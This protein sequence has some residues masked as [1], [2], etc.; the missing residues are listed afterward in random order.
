MK[1]EPR[2]ER[3]TRRDGEGK[4]EEPG[5]WPRGVD[6]VL[7]E[8]GHWEFPAQET[9]DLSSGKIHLA[10]ASGETG[11]RE[12]SLQFERPGN[13]FW[14]ERRVAPTNEGQWAGKVRAGL[15]TVCL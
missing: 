5:T 2:G 6:S 9:S 1:L 7:G 8:I 4:P 11:S 13:G 15:L 10:A 12:V 3:A 14:R